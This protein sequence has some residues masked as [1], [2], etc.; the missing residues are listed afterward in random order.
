MQTQVKYCYLR[1]AI[2]AALCAG[3]S[4]PVYAQENPAGNT[5]ENEEGAIEVI[6][7]T[8]RKRAE[9]LQ[10]V[11][12]AITAFSGAGIEAAGIES[13]ED[14]SQFS[15]GLFFSNQGNQRGGRSE[16]VIRFRGMD[17]ND[18]SPTKQLAS[19]FVDGVYVSGGLASLSM[20]GVDRVEVI[21]G[22]QSAYFGRSTFGGAVNI[23]TRRPSWTPQSRFVA[24]IAEGN[25]FELSGTAEGPM[26][27]DVLTGRI[28]VRHYEK[29]GRYRSAADG[30][31]LGEERT[32][33]I[34]GALY[35]EPNEYF[36]AQLR[37]FYGED[38]DGPPTT[39]ALTR[40]LHNCGP[41]FA[42][43]VSYFCGVLPE[44]GADRIGTNTQLNDETR[45]IY[46]NNSRNSEALSR[47]P[48]IDG[49]GMKRERKR[50]SLQ[51]DYNMPDTEITLTSVSFYNTEAQSRLLDLD[52]TPQNVWIEGSFQEI[53]DWGQELRASGSIDKVNW[54]IGASYFDLTYETP[55]GS[56]GYLYPNATFPNGFFL[57]QTLAKDQASATAIFGSVSY[58][59]TDTITASLEGRYQEDTIDEGVVAGQDLKKTFKNFL[60]RVI[61]QWQP[62][63]ETNLYATYSEGNKPGDFNSSIIGLNALQ[64]QEVADQTGAAEFLEEEQLKN[65]EIGLKQ[66]LFDGRF[67]GSAAVYFMEWA[68]QQSRTQATITDLNTPAGIRAVPVLVSAGETELWGLEFEGNARITDNLRL[69]ATLNHAAS[70]Y[71][72]FD[73]GFCER[74]TGN[75]DQ[76]GN[77]T[78][79]FPKWSGSASLSYSKPLEIDLPV[80]GD[81]DWFVRTDA[82]YTGKAFEEAVNLAWTDPYWRV[83]LRAGL[84]GDAWKVEIFA[85][86]LFDDDS[87][88]AGARFTDFTKGNF[89]LRDFV[90][91]VS[92]AEPR[93]IGV[94]V[95]VK[96]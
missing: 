54:L 59:V 82:L 90:T 28:S 91:N 62:T 39:F 29:G 47:G 87:Y 83:N 61:L 77:E 94:R 80:S 27:E 86:N 4:A 12:L 93:Q 76:S 17:I 79:R 36:S 45:D 81:V 92:P 15:P 10:D 89:N 14:I 78:P 1:S 7:V 58:D 60:P 2:F 68:N 95:S 9:S 74:I 38:D 6:L 96:F 65:Y 16:S 11:P 64:K 23:I 75:P 73:C 51:V 63:S 31:K 30:G 18:V 43:G 26:I 13:L 32:F 50:I 84:E 3:T 48:G 20:E 66:Q 55:N 70:E 67:S 72:V 40:D 21:K 22:P 44:V 53:E 35:F 69:S 57:D 52:F 19:V 56:I 49:F 8:S 88:E 85:R 46:I 71:I 24:T 5:A 37:G 41:F 33:S 34:D 25:Q 42:G